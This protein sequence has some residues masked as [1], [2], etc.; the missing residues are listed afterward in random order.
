MPRLTAGEIEDVIRRAGLVRI[1]TVDDSGFPLVTPAGFLY[2][3][4]R[5]LLTA[6]SRVTWLA[7]IRRDP[8]VCVCVDE[9]R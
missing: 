2:R 1:A 5:L 6:R 7:H 8:R 9:S 4:G 3:D